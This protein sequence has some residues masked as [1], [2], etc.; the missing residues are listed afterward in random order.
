[1]YLTLITLYM[2]V[3]CVCFIGKTLDDM[4]KTRGLRQSKPNV[5]PFQIFT[6]IHISLYG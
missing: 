6:A 1:M 5:D 2:F 4:L 3:V